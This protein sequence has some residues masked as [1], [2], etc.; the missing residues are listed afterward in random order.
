MMKQLSITALSCS[1][2]IALTNPVNAEGFNVGDVFYCEV[3]SGAFAEPPNFEFTVWKPFN[4]KFKIVSRNLIKYGSG[5]YFNNIEAK[6]GFMSN[7]MLETNETFSVFSLY[8]ERFN[9]GSAG[10]AG[11]SMMTGTCDKF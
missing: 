4:F 2:L 6:I 10:V 5:G 11:S 9:Y 7:G 8:K 1:A 3:E